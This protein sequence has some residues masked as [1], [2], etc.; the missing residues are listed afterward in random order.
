MHSLFYSISY[1]SKNF[2]ILLVATDNI[3]IS[4]ASRMNIFGFLLRIK[5]RIRSFDT[6]KV[7]ISNSMS[8]LKVFTGTLIN[9]LLIYIIGSIFE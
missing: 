8:G 4:I 6:Y 7:C 2:W 1:N 3:I 9:I 5:E